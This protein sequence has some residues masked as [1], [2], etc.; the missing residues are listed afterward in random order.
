VTVPA[1]VVPLGP[2]PPF[3]WNTSPGSLSTRFWFQSAY[4]VHLSDENGLVI[5]TVTG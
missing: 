4:T 2:P 1:N 3:S 5:V